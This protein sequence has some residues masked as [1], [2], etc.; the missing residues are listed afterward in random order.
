MEISDPRNSN[1]ATVGA[2]LKAARLKRGH[3]LEVLQNRTRIQKKFLVALEEGRFDDFPARV[4]LYGFMKSYCEYLEVDFDALW[5]QVEPPPPAG[6]RPPPQAGAD[7]AQGKPPIR[8]PLPPWAVPVFVAGL[9]AAAIL[10]ALILRSRAPA[11]G[12]MSEALPRT[13]VPPPPTTSPGLRSPARLEG[14]TVQSGLR[15]P[16]LAHQGALTLE[17]RFDEEAWLRVVADDRT[18]FEGRAPKGAVQKWQADRGFALRLSAPE[19]VRFALN[20]RELKVPELARDA[21]GDYI[22]TR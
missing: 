14:G 17:V 10:A 16:A 20:G 4:Y 22:I 19:A 21:S 12:G 15:T 13:S 8:R 9:V 18:Q 6:E 3:S 11:P 7:G 5:T 2:Q 1:S